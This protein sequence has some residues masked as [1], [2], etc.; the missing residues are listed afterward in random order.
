MNIMGRRAVSEAVVRGDF[1]GVERDVREF[2]GH[3][4]TFAV[5]DSRK[6]EREC[7]V[8]V[9]KASHEKISITAYSS[10]SE[11]SEASDPKASCVILLNIGGRRAA[12][13]T[14]GAALEG[15]VAEAGETP[16]IVLSES[17]DLRDMIAAVDCGARG[18][19][20]ASVGV[21]AIIE[22]A[23]LTSAG[24]IFLPASSLLALRDAI[25][26]DADRPAGI[27]EHFTSRQAAVAD[28]LRRGKAN[29]TI[30][31]ELNMCESTVK[32]HIRTIMKK[33][34]A[35]NRTQAAFKLNALFPRDQGD[36]A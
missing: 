35:S 5:I 7:F 20:P 31:Y 4:T 33:L 24:G 36:M 22:A 1:A 17:E 32:V 10:V 9:I 34:R 25:T 2:D 15:L 11:W 16:V 26:K 27:E 13:R 19:I 29:K 21:D 30:A 3:M 28:A 6:L 18:Y 23:R 8:R 14:V 12:V